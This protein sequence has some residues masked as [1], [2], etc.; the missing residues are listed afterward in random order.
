MK[1]EII[2]FLLLTLICT[3]GCKKWL[4]AKPKT[5]VEQSQLFTS[6]QGFE[7][8]M[9]GV[10]TLMSNSSLYGDQLT[11]SFMDVLAQNYSCQTLPGHNFYQAAIYNYT[12]AGVKTRI[13]NIW[14][15]MYYAIT[16]VNNVLLNIDAKQSLFQPGNYALV[17]GEA[18]GLRAFMHFDLL[19]MFGGSYPSHTSMKAIPYVTTVSGGVTPLSAES[20][21]LDSVI[22]DLTAASGL[23]S[24]DKTI[25][26]NFYVDAPNVLNDWLNRR[27]SHFNYWAAE[28]TLA[29]AYLYKGDKPNALLHATNV[30]N[31][32]MFSFETS[33]RISNFQDYTF[34]PEQ[35]FALSKFNLLPQVTSYFKTPSGTINTGLSVQLT[36][37]YGNGGVVDQIYEITSGGVTDV[38]YARLWALSGNVYFDTKFWQDA[39]RPEFVNLVPLM[40]LPEMYYIAAEC[41]DPATA[42]GYLNTVRENRGISD[43][44]AGLDAPTIQNE[45]FKEYEKEF[46]AEG[47]LFYYYKRLNLPQI[48]FSTIPASDNIYILPLPDAELQYRG[49]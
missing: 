42:T 5:V 44:P 20:V 16:N 47:Q 11:M 35:I 7:D 28:A 4:D 13:T 32:G 2:A 26:P 49:Q 15:S 9:Y 6:E 33:D 45:I 27:Q 31:S 23:L 25:D 12:D 34:I 10:Y 22:A 29:R 19:R 39:P 38:R 40:R 21:L 41:S 37:T 48:R 14:D 36:N 43:L 18:L 8:A 30:I 17:K 3:S 24:G 1:K 46:Y